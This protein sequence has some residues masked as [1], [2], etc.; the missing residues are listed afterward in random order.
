[1]RNG[2]FVSVYVQALPEVVLLYGRVS[3]EC[4]AFCMLEVAKQYIRKD[5]SRHECIALWEVAKHYIRNVMHLCEC[6]ASREVSSARI[7]RWQPI[8]I[9]RTNSLY[10]FMQNHCRCMAASMLDWR[11]RLKPWCKPSAWQACVGTL[12]EPVT[13]E[14]IIDAT[15][16][17]KAQGLLLKLKQP[18]LQVRSVG[19]MCRLRTRGF[20]RCYV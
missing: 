8:C 17:L 5:A 9:T 12:P 6:N 13:T 3:G 15:E 10:S 14:E 4:I 16:T 18:N 19:C 11:A 7:H 20:A 2:C 1:M